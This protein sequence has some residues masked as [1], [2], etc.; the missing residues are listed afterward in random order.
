VNPWLIAAPVGALAAAGITAY[1]AVNPH[2]QLFGPM[3]WKTNSRK[4]LAIT[5]DD[6]PNP[7]VTPQLLNALE[8]YG[9]HAT[10]F[11]VGRFARQCPALMREICDR[12]HTVANHTES[13]ANLFWSSPTQIAKQIQSC[14]DAIAETT[15]NKPVWFRPPWGMRNPWVIPAAAAAGLRTA[16]WSQ[17][18]GD[19]RGKPASWLIKKM[20]PITDSA[21]TASTDSRRSGHV[22]CLH[23]GDY[24]F[25][26]ADRDATVE[27]LEY[28][29]PRW[30]DLG[31]E[32]VTIDDA[33]NAP[34]L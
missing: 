25:L 18:P 24:R 10:F 34:A 11:V 15:G 5:F 26:N 14:N 21:K 6:G 32:F 3:V 7:A 22:L 4:K 33:V 23:D 28:C 29:L 19:W 27:A 1:G 12:G 8:R 16:L 2:S 20:E 13:H 30:R 31:L 17:L 9:A